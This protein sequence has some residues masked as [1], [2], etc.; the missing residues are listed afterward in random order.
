MLPRIDQRQH[1][2]HGEVAPAGVVDELAANPVRDHDRA[3]HL[4]GP[5][6]QHPP[7]GRGE[8]RLPVQVP[9]R[10]RRIEVLAPVVLDGQPD[11][12]I[13]EIQQVRP[14]RVL[15]QRL[16]Q[17]APDHGQPDPGLH[18]GPG[19]RVGQPQDLGQPPAPAGA[20]VAAVQLPQH[21]QIEGVHPGQGVE[22]HHP[23]DQRVC[24]ARSYA[25][26]GAV[27]TAIPSIVVTSSGSS[28]SRRVSRPGGRRR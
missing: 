17:P 12:G 11:R 9:Q 27:V 1:L 10:P 22:R 2:G 7:P 13:R 24:R 4:G 19:Q 8:V 15:Q 23:V 18:R 6:P 5:E 21:R 3:V 26:R 14:D 20:E 28:R 25:V 16:R